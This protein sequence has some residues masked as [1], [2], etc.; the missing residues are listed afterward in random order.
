MTDKTVFWEIFVEDDYDYDDY[1]DEYADYDEE[2]I[3]EAKKWRDDLRKFFYYQFLIETD[4]LKYDPF[5]ENDDSTEGMIE[6]K[7][8]EMTKKLL[9]MK[10][11]MHRTTQFQAILRAFE[12]KDRNILEA[13]L[14]RVN[15]WSTIHMAVMLTTAIFQVFLLRSFF[16]AK[17][18]ATGGR[19]MT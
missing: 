13:N 6:E 2:E 16:S 19:A 7:V 17:P 5:L 18:T 9:K 11:N 3:A 8:Q 4:L 10:T 12:S 15:N 14:K 1:D